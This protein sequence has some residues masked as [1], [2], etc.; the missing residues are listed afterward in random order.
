MHT[1]ASSKNRA[2]LEP[3][4]QEEETARALIIPHRYNDNHIRLLLLQWPQS[5]IP[6]RPIQPSLQ[7]PFT[8]PRIHICAHFYHV[9]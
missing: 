6:Q 4:H 1:Q 5:F 2:D 7:L 9:I 3:I 8:A